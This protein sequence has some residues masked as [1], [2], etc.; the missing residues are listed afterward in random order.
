MVSDALLQHRSVQTRRW[1]I[2]LITEL[3]S[4][5]FTTLA[6]TDPQM[7]SP[8][9]LHAILNLFEGEIDIRE[10][11]TEKGLEKILKIKRMSNQKYMKDETFLT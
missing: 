3:K 4:A 11:E 10:K 7:H 8:E 1:L 6:V 2:E 5:G 9:E